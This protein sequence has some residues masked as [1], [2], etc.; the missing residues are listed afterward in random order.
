MEKLQRVYYV[1]DEPDIRLIADIA[2]TQVGG[3][4]VKMSDSGASAL[5]DIERFAPQLVLLDV[6]MP[7][8]DGPA[9]LRRVRAEHKFNHI[10]V[11]FLTAK[12]QASELEE[13]QALGANAVISKPFD[14][15][16]LAAQLQAIWQQSEAEARH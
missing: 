11:V 7:G 3:M 10:P 6:M 4:T 12:V 8:I 14:P 5:A 1:E 15:M 13:L 16:T 2:L 9:T